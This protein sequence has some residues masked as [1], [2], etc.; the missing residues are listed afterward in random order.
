[1][2][3]MPQGNPRL[4]E[5]IN[6]SEEHPLKEFFLLFIGVSAT[7]V[8]VVIILS[9]LARVLAPY[10]PFEWER[11]ITPSATNF[12]DEDVEE[13]ITPE[14][15]IALNKLSQSLLNASLLIRI[16]GDNGEPTVPPE[17]VNFHL[18]RMGTPNAFAT[19]GGHI[20]VTEGLLGEISSENGLAMVIAHEIGHIQLRHP[21]EAAGRGVVIQLVLMAVLG[22]SGSN[23]SAG[24][25]TG[26][27]IFTMLSFNRD[28]ELAADERA[29]AI[30]RQHYGHV[31]GADEFFE[32]MEKDGAI[33]DWLEFSQTHPSTER[34]L[35]LIRDAL[36]MDDEYTALTPLPPELK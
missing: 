10:I 36:A 35:Q 4:P 9:V 5:G 11:A 21:I 2:S 31:G 29:L 7:I 27:S 22:S 15:E 34:R 20:F 23:A 16:E 1:M 17:A 30:L 6:A 3:S 19:L 26:A 24:I 14:R 8:V 18:L 12:V 33:E 28:M 25:L 13:S 32:A